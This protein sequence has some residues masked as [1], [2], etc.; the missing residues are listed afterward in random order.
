MENQL[1]GYIYIFVGATSSHL[2]HDFL[3][4]RRLVG[5]AAQEE[6]SQLD[7]EVGEERK[8]SYNI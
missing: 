3:S 1:K 8:V 7:G 6:L 2:F 5:K 4:L